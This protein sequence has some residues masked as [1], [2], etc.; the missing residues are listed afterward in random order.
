[1]KPSVTI[2]HQPLFKMHLEEIDDRIGM[3]AVCVAVVY[4]QYLT[5]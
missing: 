3:V 4:K 2:S 5:S 1:V